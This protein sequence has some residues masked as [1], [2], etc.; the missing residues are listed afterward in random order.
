MRL[1]AG[2]LLFPLHEFVKGHST[3]KMLTEMEIIQWQKR[4]QIME[5]Q[6]RK[7]EHLFAYAHKHVPYF[8]ELSDY[9]LY[10]HGTGELPFLTKKKI[11]ENLDRLCSVNAGSLQRSNTGGSTGEPLIFYLGKRRVSSDIA[12]KVRA[13][14]WWNVDVGDREVVIWGSPV[15]LTKQD[16]MRQLRD[17]LLRT[18]LLSAFD[19]SEKTML[20]YIAFIQKYRPLHVFGYPSSIS[21]LCQFARKKNLR[22][23]DL[24]VK[25]VFCTAEKLYDYQ[26][27]LISDAFSAPVANGYGGRDAGFIAHECPQG[28]MHIA[29][30]NV[31]VEIIDSQGNTVPVGEA[32]EIVVTHL[33]SHDFP[34]IRYRTGDVGSLSDENCPCGRGLT[35][36][37][38]VEGRSTD[39]IITPDGRIMHGLAL[40]Y[41]VR[42]VEGVEAFKILQEDYDRILLVLSINGNYSEASEDKIRTGLRKRLGE[43][44]SIDITYSEKIFPERSG[45]FRYVE[46]K[47]SVS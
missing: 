22:L 15:E 40:I 9:Q 42:D 12:A 26:R 3:I 17:W 2:K 10:L 11:R 25:V 6:N 36:L 18:K 16:K 37:R 41:E 31:V 45:K 32:G 34:F 23:S 47:V 21:L 14:R 13:T 39:F 43:E 28:S 24:G 44:V 33:E 27:E 30:D 5:I 35:V 19:M 20:E 7:M 46:S 38:S 8:R 4:E 1:A 29:D